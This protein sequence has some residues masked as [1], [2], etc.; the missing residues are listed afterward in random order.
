M[1]LVKVGI[2]L[3][4]IQNLLGHVSLNLTVVYLKF[5]NTKAKMLMREKELI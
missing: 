2:L 5:S 3:T 1:E 4:I